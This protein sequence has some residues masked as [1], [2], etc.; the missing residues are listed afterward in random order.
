MSGLPTDYYHFY[1]ACGHGTA[2]EIRQSKRLPEY[3]VGLP[4]VSWF[5]QGV[6]NKT[7][8][9]WWCGT[10]INLL[11]INSWLRIRR[12]K[13]DVAYVVVASDEVAARAYSL[14]KAL[15]CPYVVH[16]FDLYHPDGLDP[17][18]MSGFRDLLGGAS[19][20]LTLTSAMKSELEKFECCAVEEIFIGQP[21]TQHVATP[22]GADQPIRVIM[23]GRPYLGGCDF[24]ATACP[25]LAKLDRRIEILNIGPHFNDI[26]PSLRPWVTNL[27]FID[28]D[29][30]YRRALADAHIGFLSG[31]SEMDCLGRYSF[32]SRCAEYLMAGLPS[33]GC[34]PDRSAAAR[35]V[36]PITPVAFRRV[37]S[38][39]D[40]VEAINGFT[41]SDESWRKASAVARD[42]A[43]RNFSVESKRTILNARFEAAYLQVGTR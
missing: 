27:G 30:Q 31:P 43:I 42:F 13:F 3:E 40:F 5:W 11:R 14:V 4:M 23:G 39:G 33:V 37:A 15:A 12:F 6:C 8:G 34:I 20:I 26:P 29:E 18:R 24:L 7:I 10:S 1:F 25:T 17:A 16:V 35:V 21:V 38:V 36:S 9:P 28:N 41:Q 22:P 19:S 32:P 2:S